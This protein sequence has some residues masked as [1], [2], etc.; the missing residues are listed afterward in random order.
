[1][2]PCNIANYVS[3]KVVTEYIFE[4]FKPTLIDNVPDEKTTNYIHAV[5][6][7]FHDKRVSGDLL[8]QRVK[9]SIADDRTFTAAYADSSYDHALSTDIPVA[10][11]AHFEKDMN[12][13]CG[14]L[15]PAHLITWV[16]VRPTHRRR[17]LLR[18]LMT[19][20]L[21]N[22]ADAGYP[23]AALTVTEG[24][25]YRRFGFGAASWL[26]SIEV[27]TSP[28]FQLISEADR[29]VEMCDARALEELAPQIYA[30]FQKLSPGAIG[31]Q[32][33]LYDFAAG[34]DIEGGE[35]DNAV[36]GALHYDEN[37]KPDG[38]VSYKHKSGDDWSHG[39]LQLLDFVAVSNE[40]YSALWAFLGAIDLSMKVTFH[41]AAHQSPLPWLITDPRRAKIVEECDGVWLRMLDVKKAL[42]ARAWLVGGELTLRI[43][44]DMGFADGTFRLESDGQKA[45]VTKLDGG[46]LADLEMNVS[47]LGSLYLGGA[48]PVVLA[49]AGRITEVRPGAALE[50]RSLFALE[51]A[52]YTP[53]DF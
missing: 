3:L 8:V 41:A 15:I 7:G 29:R 38:F 33:A 11:F 12:V 40:A 48:D 43:H 34:H 10:T 50:A 30:E 26:T 49:R 6:A 20:N 9:R 21:T 52:P 14:R 35:S 24:G 23:F 18:R 27:D 19:E 13:G 42:E 1:M 51:R 46:E 31:R 25:I 36:R 22:A 45:T 4:T 5:R 53:N 2:I 44:D 16:T 39:T 47:E 28:G 37:G 17:G 32:Q